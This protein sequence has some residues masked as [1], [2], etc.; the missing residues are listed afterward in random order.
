[1]DDDLALWLKQ[2]AAE[3]GEGD[4]GPLK[5]TDAPDPIVI[6]DFDCTLAAKH[7]E[8]EDG[9]LEGV[10][11]SRA[12]YG[13]LERHAELRDMLRDIKAAG[14]AVAVLTYNSEHTVRRC[15]KREIKDGLLRASDVVGFESFPG[16]TRSAMDKGQM[17][18]RKWCEGR[19]RPRPV[20]FVDDTAQNCRDVES[21]VGS[22][23]VIDVAANGM[24]FT[25]MNKVL[26][27]ARGRPI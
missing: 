4:M 17:I 7:A 1:M 24:S 3:Y 15:L 21:R 23:T 8:R 6:F 18:A 5:A 22:A 16:G 25:E 20:L 19:S 12:V 2:S 27:W 26:R 11:L 14:A 9:E 10:A 13:G